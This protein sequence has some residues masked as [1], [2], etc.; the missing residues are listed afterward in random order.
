MRA[1]L[2]RCALI[3]QVLRPTAPRQSAALL[4]EAAAGARSQKVGSLLTIGVIAA[5]CATVLLTA[6]RTA[7]TE[8]AVLGSIDSSGTR[9]IVVRAQQ[10][11]GLD[12]SVLARLA[13]VDGIEW[14]AAFGPADDVTNAVFAG[15]A[16][17]P[18]RAA[19]SENWAP[20]G[21]PSGPVAS[22][23]AARTLGFADR[24]GTAESVASHQSVDIAATLPVPGYLHFLEPLL[25]VPYSV[26]SSQPSPNPS[27]CSWSWPPP[28]GRS[29]VSPPW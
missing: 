7:A 23:L 21:D 14:V 20:L 15:G 5:L 22:D 2:G 24:V 28:P 4:R 3:P 26:A 19:Y 1:T 12:T 16:K 25:I 6:G 29:A 9:S 17:V 8:S 13:H 18:M 27:T 11:A 10:G